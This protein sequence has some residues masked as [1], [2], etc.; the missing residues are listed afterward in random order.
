MALEHQTKCR[1]CLPLFLECSTNQHKNNIRKSK[2]RKWTLTAILVITIRVCLCQRDLCQPVKKEQRHAE[3]EPDAHE[4]QLLHRR[5]QLVVNYFESCSKL[6]K[7][8]QYFIK[9]LYNKQLKVVVFCTLHAAIF[10][11]QHNHTHNESQNSERLAKHNNYFIP[12]LNEGKK[13]S[14]FPLSIDSFPALAFFVLSCEHLVQISFCQSN[15][16][17]RAPRN[18]HLNH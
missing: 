10:L 11:G 4:E 12:M 2:T 15:N 6:N 7:I 1:H 9:A 14:P 17:S 3:A 18:C 13:K 16:Q 5:F 8:L